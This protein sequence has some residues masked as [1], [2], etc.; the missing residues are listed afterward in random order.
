MTNDGRVRILDF[1]LGK[2]RLPPFGVLLYVHE[3]PSGER[4]FTGDSSVE[5]MNA[6]L[7]EEPNDLLHRGLL[8]GS[9]VALIVLAKSPSIAWPQPLGGHLSVDITTMA[10]LDDQDDE[11]QV[12]NL[13]QDSIVPLSNSV[14]IV[15]REFLGPCRSRVTRQRCDFR[16]DP[17]AVLPGDG[18]DLLAGRRLDEQ[19][20]A[21]HDAEG[22]SQRPR[23]RGSVRSLWHET[24]R[25]RRR[26]P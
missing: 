4:K 1:G 5:V 7:K 9:A 22:P 20:I 12:L 24:P 13:V 15:P 18:F 3:M 16:D 11:I 6:I 2:L 23:N 21:C 25:D 19:L 26:P 10:D 17:P 14:V 8:P